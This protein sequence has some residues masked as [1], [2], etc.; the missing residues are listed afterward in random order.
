V[1]KMII[2]MWHAEFKNLKWE[3]A[4]SLGKVSFTA[5]IWTDG[6]L[7]PYLAVTAHWIQRCQDGTLSLRADLIAFHYL[8]GSHDGKS[9]CS[10]IWHLLEHASI[11]VDKVCLAH[12]CESDNN[13]FKNRLVGGHLTMPQTMPPL[14]LSWSES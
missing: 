10:A 5:D 8:P 4:S 13:E 6:V 14:W 9:I 1:R 11:P 7:W 12:L 2:Q 3:V